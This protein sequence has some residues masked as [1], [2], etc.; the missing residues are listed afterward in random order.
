MPITDFAPCPNTR[1][2]TETPKKEGKRNNKKEQP[3]M[4]YPISDLPTVK[5][6]N[7]KKPGRQE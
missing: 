3:R 5:E 7:R 1:G 6:N 4:T 2:P